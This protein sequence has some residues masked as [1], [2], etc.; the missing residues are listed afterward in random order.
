MV[1]WSILAALTLLLGIRSYFRGDSINYG[2]LHEIE[3]RESGKVGFHVGAFI[4][5]A[6]GILRVGYSDRPDPAEHRSVSAMRIDW[7]SYR[8][9]EG[10]PLIPRGDLG[11]GFDFRWRSQ[12]TAGPGPNAK[13]ASISVPI[14][15]V[16]LVCCW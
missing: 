4:I 16:L 2:R 1:I 12:Y 7:N 10:A 14:W 13:A 3:R 11:L 8:V 15:F 5:S 6:E 9:R